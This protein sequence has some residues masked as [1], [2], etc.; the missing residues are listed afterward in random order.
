MQSLRSNAWMSPL[1]VIIKLLLP[2]VLSTCRGSGN[3]P[4][5]S[6]TALL[7]PS[8]SWIVS[9]DSICS[10]L[11]FVIFICINGRDVILVAE[12]DQI[13]G[14]F[15]FS[16]MPMCG[17]PQCGYPDAPLFTRADV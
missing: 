14:G 7:Q 17:L 5:N 8:S 16:R 11:T 4:F 3:S 13:V 15:A 1:G 12:L 2:I 6:A 10:V 9:I